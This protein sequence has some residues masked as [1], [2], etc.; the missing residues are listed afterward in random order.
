MVKYSGDYLNNGELSEEWSLAFD[1]S[2]IFNMHGL[3]YNLYQY[4]VAIGK[5]GG[6][7]ALTADKRVNTQNDC[8]KP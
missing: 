8:R 6:Y 1:N 7:I 5:N 3:K 2:N 4:H